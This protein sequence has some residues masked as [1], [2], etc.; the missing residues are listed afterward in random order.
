MAQ[1][2]TSEIEKITEFKAAYT[3][4]TFN[5]KNFAFYR[6]DGV[7]EGMD[8][9]EA[10]PTQLRITAGAFIQR[11][12]VIELL[13]DF[14]VDQ[15]GFGFPWTIYADTGDEASST[16]TFIAVAPSGS[17]PTGVVILG[18]TEDGDTFVLPKK[19]SIKEICNTIQDLENTQRVRR[20]FLCNAGFELINPFKGLSF[21][22]P[23]PVMDCWEADNLTDK[24]SGS[25]LAVTTDPLQT[26]RGGAAILL[27]SEKYLDPGGLQPDLTSLPARVRSN[28]RI[29]QSVEGYQDLVGEPLTFACSLRLPPGHAAQLHDLEIS[30]YGSAIGT[31]GF[32]DTPVDKFSFVIPAATLS[33]NYQRFFVQGTIVNLNAGVVTVPLPALPGITARVAFINSE[34]DT[35]P[36]GE[37]DKVLI[38]DCVLY[39]GAIDNPS[40][41]PIPAAVDWLRAESTFE[42]QNFEKAELGMSTDLDYLL[43]GKVPFSS[44][45]RGI[46][47][48]STDGLVV[49]ED[50]SAFATNSSGS[51]TPG[52]MA[53]GRNEY[54]GRVAKLIAGFRPA[55][56]ETVV[57][58]Q[59]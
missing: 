54:R 5:K 23:G 48:V 34:P 17:E 57:R 29:Y 30:I 50:G 55:R 47:T 18:T 44:K 6:I 31:P 32:S 52:F 41:F 7:L 15:P 49:N 19:I 45:K 10:N 21:V 42:A 51:Y 27:E 1:V 38:D 22:F 36:V 28:A 16:P 20:N 33:Q 14:L 12:I 58:A 37:I 2:P 9:S 24:A 46:P 40:F 43:A 59:N 11:G 25:V 8:V 53:T 13:T 4:K 3:S 26:L 35:F 39:Q 56:V